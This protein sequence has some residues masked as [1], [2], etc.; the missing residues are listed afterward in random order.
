MY[1]YDPGAHRDKHKWPK[2]RP[3]FRLRQGHPV[4]KCPAGFSE[5]KA[6]ELLHSGVPWPE[7][8]DSAEDPPKRIYNVHEGVPYVGRRNAPG[9]NAYHAHPVGYRRL[10]RSLFRAL[11]K[12]AEDQGRS[13]EFERWCEEHRIQIG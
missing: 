1:R 5:K 13:R 6:R 12:R 4:G 9:S 8:W 10:S 11:R 2:K 3:G 7:E